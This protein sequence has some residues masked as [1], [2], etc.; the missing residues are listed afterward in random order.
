MLYFMNTFSAKV[1][2]N[3]HNC[4]MKRVSWLCTLRMLPEDGDLIQFQKLYAALNYVWHDTKLLNAMIT[5]LNFTLKSSYDALIKF[6]TTKSMKHFTEI[7]LTWLN[8]I[9]FESYLHAIFSWKLLHSIA[10]YESHQW[11]Y[12]KERNAFSSCYT[13]SQNS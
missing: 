11:N 1:K 2:I 4:N 9:I 7:L 10:A 13:F 5:C 6:Y 3:A 12:M 8:A